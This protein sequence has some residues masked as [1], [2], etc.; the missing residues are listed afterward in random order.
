MKRKLLYLFL[1]AI[2]PIIAQ[3]QNQSI[4]FK[5]NIGQIVDQKNKPNTAVKFL[6][7][8]GGL[9]VQLK[10]NGF[11]YDIYEAK[12]IPC[13]TPLR[14]KAP[15]T[16]LP[17]EVKAEPDYNLEYKF[18]RIDIDFVGSNSK[19]E[20]IAEQKSKDFDNYYNIPNKPEGIVGVHQY[21]QVT[22]KNIYPNIDVVFTIPNDPKKVV[23]YNFVVHPKG[24]ISDIQLKFNGAETNLVDNKI[25]MNVRFGKMEETLPASW[26]EEG[27]SKKEIN[28]GYTKIKKNVYGFSTSDDI[29]DKKLIIDP[30]PV[31]LWGTYFGGNSGYLTQKIK[32]DNNENIII[33]GETS[34][35]TNIATAGAFQTTKISI[36]DASFLSKLSP[37]G[38]RIWGSY[39]NSAIIKDLAI[40]SNNDIYI[41]GS[42]YGNSSGDNLTTSGAYKTANP[43]FTLDGL[44][45]KFNTDGQQIWGTL[46]GGSERDLINTL[47]LD[48]DENLIIGGET[49]STNDIATASAFQSINN[50]PFDG[51]G[52]FAKFSPLGNRISASYFPGIIKYST[53]DKNNDLIFAGQYWILD[54]DQPNIST[55]GAHQTEIHFMDGFIV[56][57]NP[58]GQRLWCTYYGGDASFHISVNDYYDRITGIGSDASNNIYISGTTN[59]INNISTIGAHKENQ[60]VGG[61]D[62]FLAKFN[63]E[64][65]RQ[66]GTYYGSENA[67]G[68]D[69]CE[70]S[71]TSD[72]GNIYITGNTRSQTDIVTPDTFQSASNG[73]DEGFISKFDT[74]GNLVWGTYYGGDHQ[75]YLKGI[76]FSNA[77]VYTI[78]STTGSNNLGTS[79]TEY[80]TISGGNTFIAKFQDCLTNPILSSNS[81]I[82]IGNTLELKASGG[83]TYAWTGPNGFTSSDQNPTILNATAINSG[84]YSCLITGT[85]GCDDTKKIDVV[86]GDV[87]API[88]DLTNL[89]AVTGDCNTVITIVPTAT[90]VCAGA[91]TATTTNPLSYSL[92]GTYTIVWNYDDGNG[93]TS[94]QNQTVNIS[95]QPLPIVN[96]NP[97]TFCFQQNA[98]LNDIDIAGQNL[99]WYDELIAGTLLTNTT[100]LEDGKTYYASQTI[101][102]CESDR[103]AVG[104]TILNTPVPTGIVNQTFCTGDNPTLANILVEGENIKWYDDAT[105]LSVLANT[106]PLQ[107]GKTYYASQTI[108][109][110]ESN[111]IAITVA[112]QNTPAIPTG[113]SNQSFCKIENATLNNLIL[114]GQN[115]KWYDS[116]L[117]TTP[118]TNATLLEN[119]TTYYASQTIGC[120]SGRFPVLVT[121]YDTPLPTGNSN[122]IFCLDQ[123]ATISDVIANGNDLKWYDAAVNGNILQNTTILEDGLN[124]YVSQTLNNC[125]SPRLAITIKIQDTKLPIGENNQK[126]CVQ[127]NATISDINITGQNIKWYNALTGG[128]NLS[129]MTPL[130]NGKTYYASQTINSCESDRNTFSIQ[131]LEATTAD[132]I[133]FEDELPY[134]KFFTPNND[135]YN[136]TWTI[137]FAYLAPNSN[138]RIFN[139]YGKFIKELSIHTAWDGTYIGR[140]EPSSDY[141]FVVTRLN[142]AEFRG[143]FTL[144][145]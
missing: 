119:N 85:G 24:K 33:T 132:C 43:D 9:N 19:V 4:G 58:E 11:S 28:I 73:S 10:K 87:E 104:V 135:G 103:V 76:F 72:N 39:I 6:L 46:Y 74:M 53:I 124:Y 47:S 18:H 140:D 36:W 67:Q 78:G 88:P 89:P 107:D 5:E 41:G 35:S 144:K 12:K 131:I 75:D 38:N 109:N 86:I 95:S 84:E 66:W 63:S 115:L 26:T 64:G 14:K 108:N 57:F 71:F 83:T 128:E 122:Q 51:C 8:T 81:P 15:D 27:T 7:N 69:N 31:R 96:T 110:C 22:Y 93:N 121:I 123:N 25:Q 80:P 137:D 99:K 92:P 90:D 125:E 133:N 32:T 94:T 34:S 111:R 141:W 1:L 13:R 16:H 126:F 44:I 60:E 127:E 61:V 17:K 23:E 100:L 98:T 112:V 55:S 70:S 106:V 105:S 50:D 113:D 82:C 117:P 136:D 129:N 138:I 134:P 21:K 62:T 68:N 54:S 79:G 2:T 52:F 145:R 118:L 142:G 20:L 48:N 40:N 97:Q 3:N 45:L 143:H 130:E 116:D 49:H 56:K 30:V 101:N 77:Y 65:V 37:N 29:S 139:R 42:D 91:I 114:T 102:G 59:S 120:E